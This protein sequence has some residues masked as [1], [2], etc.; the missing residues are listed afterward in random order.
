MI[1]PVLLADRGLYQPTSRDDDGRS[2]DSSKG[3][4]VFDSA[5]N[6]SEDEQVD[7]WGATGRR[8]AAHPGTMFYVNGILAHEI[9]R[10]F[11]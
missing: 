1:D 3:S 2:D 8:E 6:E 7:G 5:R 4:A 11:P 10:F 9:C